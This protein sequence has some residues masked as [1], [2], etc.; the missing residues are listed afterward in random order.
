M[1]PLLRPSMHMPAVASTLA[2]RQARSSHSPPHSCSSAQ[3]VRGRARV[4][5][6]TPKPTLTLDSSSTNARA[7]AGGRGREAEVVRGHVPAAGPR[8]AGAAGA[9]QRDARA[10]A[11]A[12]HARARRAPPR[13]AGARRAL[14][15]PPR[16]PHSLHCPPASNMMGRGAPARGWFDG[17][18]CGGRRAVRREQMLCACAQPGSPQNGALTACRRPCGGRCGRAWCTRW[19]PRPSRATRTASSC[20]CARRRAARL[21]RPRPELVPPQA[22]GGPATCAVQAGSV[23]CKRKSGWH[24]LLPAC[25]TRA[26]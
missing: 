23:A 26:Q 19:P 12:N 9:P 8:H 6:L 24:S 18:A 16:A 2:P 5:L 15:A 11:A 4:R 10:A 13:A 14:A 3:A 25:C 20:G 17:M 7:R 22:C 1:R 21:P